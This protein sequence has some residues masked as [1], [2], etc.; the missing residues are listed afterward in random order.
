MEFLFKMK[1]N[2]RDMILL[3]YPFSDQTGIKVRPAIVISNNNYNKNSDDC[4]V[5]PL[6]SVIKQNPYSILIS[7]EDLASGKLIKP[8]QVQVNKIFTIEKT[9]VI[10]KFA[11]INTQTFNKIKS[12]ISKLF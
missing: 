2:Q 4:L 7:Q 12:E 5:V 8:S 6:T 3:P 10:M 9:S 1:I 11:V